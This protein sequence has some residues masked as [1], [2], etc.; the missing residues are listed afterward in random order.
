MPRSSHLSL[1]LMLAALATL[2]PFSIDT[3]LP[4]MDAIGQALHANPLEMQQA[5]S[6][7]L[8][9]YALMMLW[10]GA[11]SDSVGRRPVVLLATLVFAVASVGCALAPNLSTLLLFRGV[12]GLCGGAGL[13]VG[14]AII[15]DR[16]DGVE[17]QRMMSQ[18]TMLFSLAPAIAPVIGGLLYG[19]FGWRSVFAFMALF[20]LGLSLWIGL[21][22]P[23]THLQRQPLAWRQLLANYRE[24]GGRREFQLLALAVTFNFA[25]F[26]V[27]IPSAPVFVMRHLGLGHNDFI[28]MFGPAVAGISAGAFLSGRLAGRRS[29]RELVT[30]GYAVMACAALANVAIAWSLPPAL[31][32]SVLPLTL[33]TTG[34][35]LAAPS[36]TLVLM[37]QFPELRGT[38]SSLQGF[39]Q[40][41]MSS[42]LAGVVSPLVWG[43]PLTLALTMSAFLLAGWGF[44]WSYR[45][46]LALQAGIDLKQNY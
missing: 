43:S 41:M 16:F 32:W 34:M 45:R 2:G 25:G 40:T 15:R 35:S 11:I 14:R 4:A 3:F 6:V 7:Y 10:H 23:E 27:Y 8:F 17:A 30:L 42:L 38:A 13:V 36:I 21:S 5:L 28:W 26:F 12:Q 37:D 19:A 9:C 29:A 44:R 39:V 33:Y 22:L 46:R 1:A 24:V 20:S 31:P 18:V